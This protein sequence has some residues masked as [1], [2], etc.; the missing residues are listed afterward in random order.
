M[1]KAAKNV[2]NTFLKFGG[3]GIA[4]QYAAGQEAKAEREA[5]EREN[6]LAVARET[7]KLRE[8]ANQRLLDRLRTEREADLAQ[9]RAR[10]SQLFGEGSL[11]RVG[12]VRSADI[13]DILARRK[14]GLEGLNAAE[15]QAL[16]EQAFSGL[17]SQAATQARQLRGAQGGAGITGA[18]AAAQQARLMRSADDQKRQLER[19]LLI[20][21]I[22]Q[23]QE[24]L[25]GYEQSLR[26]TEEDELGRRKYNLGA[27]AAEK[28]GQ[29][30]TELGYGGLGAGERSA[31]QQQALGEAMQFA[32]QANKPQGGKK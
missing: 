28:A 17:K 19:D 4:G 31:A 13:A 25:A 15:N 6:A 24:A 10:G 7:A 23:K 2:G 22:R 18:V 27:G 8:E 26:A 9:G 5:S 3:G 16:R 21:N 30:S 32:A 14:A 1:G 11:G 29:I 12:E 20:E